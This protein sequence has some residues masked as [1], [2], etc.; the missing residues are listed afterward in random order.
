MKI[1]YLF[2][3][4]LMIMYRR[5]LFQTNSV[6]SPPPHITRPVSNYDKIAERVTIVFSII[7][8]VLC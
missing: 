3:V 8:I 2:V 6:T 7:D 4:M 1:K 5:S